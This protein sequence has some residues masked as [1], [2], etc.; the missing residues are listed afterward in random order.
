MVGY[1]CS[2]LETSFAR[3]YKI[4]QTQ[5]RNLLKSKGQSTICNEKCGSTDLGFLTKL[6][7][8]LEYPCEEYPHINMDESCKP[9]NF[10][11]YKAWSVECLSARICDAN[12]LVYHVV[13]KIRKDILPCMKFL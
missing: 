8:K 6:D 10:K 7:V 3:Y 9:L 11:A 1:S 4:L 2:T 12:S 13:G 5:F